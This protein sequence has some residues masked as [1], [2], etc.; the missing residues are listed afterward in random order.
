M[1]YT[2]LAIVLKRTISKMA[3]EYIVVSV[4]INY[5]FDLFV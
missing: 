2:E 5:L 3:I 4:L 1:Q